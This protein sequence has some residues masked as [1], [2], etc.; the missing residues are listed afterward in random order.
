MR[1]GCVYAFLTG[2]VALRELACKSR[3]M[4]KSDT[5]RMPEANE[6]DCSSLGRYPGEFRSALN[7][8]QASHPNLLCRSVCNAR[9]LPLSQMH[10]D[11]S[12]MSW[13]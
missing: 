7:A 3:T 5:S 13:C 11:M 10:I 12:A 8:I 1:H 4:A 6:R 9:V 2:T